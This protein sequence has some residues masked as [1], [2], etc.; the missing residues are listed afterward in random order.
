MKKPTRYGRNEIKYYIKPSMV[1]P[2]LDQCRTFV[3]HD[4]HALNRPDYRYTIRSLYY[5]SPKLDFYWEKVDGIKVRR[6]LRIRSYNEYTKDS[7]AFLEIKRRYGTSIVKERA[8][9]NFDEIVEI[10]SDPEKIWL[11]YEQSANHSLVLGKWVDNIV[12]WSLEPTILVTYEREPYVGRFNDENDVRLTLDYNVRARYTES[13]A[14]IFNEDNMTPVVSDRVILEL[15]FNHFMPK[16]MRQMVQSM[17]LKQLSI[18]KYCMGV[19]EGI[20]NN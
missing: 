10:M 7:V 20:F 1:H 16:W 11:T 5:D 4:E 18:S 8:K 19:D 6:K 17:N 9:Y 3:E 12:R 14:E 13:P 2:I 15:K